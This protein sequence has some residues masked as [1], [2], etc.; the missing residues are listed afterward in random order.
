MQQQFH[1]D[2]TTIPHDSTLA[3]GLVP[4]QRISESMP[5]KMRAS[6]PLVTTRKL[7]KSM[8]SPYFG[9]VAVVIINQF[10]VEELQLWGVG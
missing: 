4:S 1:N 3:S 5:A 9:Q 2:S 10:L 6:P 8:N 7:R